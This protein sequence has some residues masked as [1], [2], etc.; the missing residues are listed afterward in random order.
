MD[1][2][3]FFRGLFREFVEWFFRREL[4]G[5]KL[6]WWWFGWEMVMV[7]LIEI[8]MVLPG[9]LLILLSFLIVPF[10]EFQTRS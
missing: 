4:W 6:W 8:E 1:T 9:A 7:C 2:H 10:Y 3:P 5:W